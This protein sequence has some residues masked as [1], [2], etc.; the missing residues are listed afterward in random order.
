MA[1]DDNLTTEQRAAACQ[2]G[3]ARLLAGPGTGKT[4][5]TVRHVLYLA[6]VQA[7]PAEQ[8]LVLTF[9]RAAAAE[10]RSRLRA[11]LGQDGPLP[12]VATLHSFALSTLLDSPGGRRFPTPIRI[13]DDFEERWL[14][15]ADLK[16]LLSLKDVRDVRA[17]FD[18]LSANWAELTEGT[19][20][21]PDPRFLGAWQEHREKYGYLLRC[22]LVYQLKC[23]LDEGQAVVDPTP[24][25]LVVDEYQDLNACDLAV[26]HALARAGAVLYVAGDDD[27]S[28]YGFRHARPEAIRS[29]LGEFPAAADLV[30]SECQRCDRNVLEL[31]LFVAA[32]DFR[33]IQKPIR[34]RADAGSGVV[35]ILR[36]PNQN[37]E[38]RSVA[39]LCRW[40][41]DTRTVAL[42]E[43]LVLLRTD[44]N[45]QF[46]RVVLQALQAAGVAASVATDPLAPL[47]CAKDADGTRRPG[48][49]VLLAHLRLLING[50]DSLAWRTILELQ[51]NGV[52]HAT[53]SNLY[54][55]A[56]AG[57]ERFGQ[58]VSNVAS[59]SSLLPRGGA[60]VSS[61]VAATRELLAPLADSATGHAGAVLSAL[62][63]RL[64]SGEAERS[65]VLACFERILDQSPDLNLEQLVKVLSA[66]LGSMEQDKDKSAVN[67]LTM[68]QAKGLTADAVFVL[69]AEEEYIPG[70]T[71]G[72]EREDEL[73]LLYVSLTRARHYLF[74][75]HC[76][77]RYGPQQH[78]GSRRGQPSRR[79]TPFLSGGPVQSEDGMRFVATLSNGSA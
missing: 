65:E 21:Q 32:R 35:K 30:L 67:I 59:C 44:Y 7:V 55:L 19:S 78:T 66:S 27:Q 4:F 77:N 71:H 22:E 34:A 6:E 72:T 24:S 57:G 73:R 36:F 14:I 68:H 48:G 9:T 42:G 1:W 53:V 39:R 52:G 16:E 33:R 47:N 38:A 18:Q 11:E 63:D 3:P 40:L 79:L 51:P 41:R 60:A 17:L 64:I 8:I 2:T 43:I 56:L 75:T 50:T 25:F 46:S 49:R 37:D 26:V 76:D 69:A 58:V 29:F 23:A 45:Q 54:R 12:R 5:C 70:A 62:G 74:L 61:V 28:I 13:A 31:G 10:L 20:R 15:W